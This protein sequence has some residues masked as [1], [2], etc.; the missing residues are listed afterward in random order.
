MKKVM[1]FAASL[2]LVLGLAA[3]GNSPKEAN[4]AP[5]D[6][7]QTVAKKELPYADS[8][9]RN[10]FTAEL[11]GKTYSITLERSADKELPVVTDEL[12]K[13]FYDNRV[14]VTITC[15]GTAFFSKSYTKEDF[16]GLL[17]EAESRGTVLLG[18]AF[19]AEN[20]TSQSIRLGAQV[21]QV[22]IEEGPAF[23]VEIPLN[24]GNP[25][26]VRDKNQ[27]TTGDAGRPD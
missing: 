2:A 19:D 12:G 10:S 14:E 6:S 17:S 3:C 5:T 13:E 27:D 15:G 1:R 8:N 16:S 11:G 18:M 21:G 22:G 26:I 9:L 24:G 20:S 23:C 4:E 25:R 7:T